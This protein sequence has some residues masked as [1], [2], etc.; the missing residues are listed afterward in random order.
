M[1]RN[2]ANLG[3]DF[4]NRP[5]VLHELPT[6]YSGIAHHLLVQ[7]LHFAVR[8]TARE[9]EPHHAAALYHSDEALAVNQARVYR[10]RG[11]RGSARL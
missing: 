9:R 8:A 4:S 5:H 7:N 1:K 3:A 10:R 11:K 6:R 2:E